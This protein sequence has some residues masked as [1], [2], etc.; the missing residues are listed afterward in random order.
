MHGA[1]CPP[2]PETGRPTQRTEKA[3]GTVDGEEAVTRQNGRAA[4]V[5]RGHCPLFLPH[6]AVEKQALASHRKSVFSECP[7]APELLLNGWQ[8]SKEGRNQV[9]SEVGELEMVSGA[10]TRCPQVACVPAEDTALGRCRE[11]GSGRACPLRPAGRGETVGAAPCGHRPG[12]VGLSHPW[13][14]G[15][16][17]MRSAAVI[18]LCPLTSTGHGP[19]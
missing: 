14:P 8:I 2:S 13:V 3:P 16:L 15:S 12:E 18:C 4:H 1:L 19:H 7:V 17:P 5:L 10:G 9:L 6:R 11:P